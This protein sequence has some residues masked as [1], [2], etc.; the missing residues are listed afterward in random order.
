MF[1]NINESA[2]NVDEQ[3]VKKKS[4]NLLANVFSKKNFALYIVSF[5]L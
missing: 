4:L 1:Q 3:E 2:L 5:M